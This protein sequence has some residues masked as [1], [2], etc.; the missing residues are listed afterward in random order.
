MI[1]SIKERNRKTYI[2]KKLQRVVLV[3]LLKDKSQKILK[4]MIWKI[5]ID[6]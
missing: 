5:G 2:K 3:K 1:G 4:M 6:E